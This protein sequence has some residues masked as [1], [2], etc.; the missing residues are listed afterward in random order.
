[1]SGLRCPGT[2]HVQNKVSWD[3]VFGKPVDWY[4]ISGSLLHS[5][6]MSTEKDILMTLDIDVVIDKVSEKSNLLRKLLTY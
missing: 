3:E 2:K 5:I 6:L 4:G 1:M